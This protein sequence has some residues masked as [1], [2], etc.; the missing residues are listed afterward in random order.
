[1]ENKDGSYTVAPS[2]LEIDMNEYDELII[3]AF[4]KND[5][6]F[7]NKVREETLSRSKSVY[8]SAFFHGLIASGTT[9]GLGYGIWWYFHRN[10]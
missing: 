8:K 6:T 1:M 3:A 5:P 7:Q 2:R 10:K 9:A 4:L